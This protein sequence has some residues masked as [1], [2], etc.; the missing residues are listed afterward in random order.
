MDR[1][2]YH[3]RSMMCVP[4]PKIPTG[5]PSSSLVLTS[6]VQISSTTTSFNPE[7]SS[8]RHPSTC[9]AKSHPSTE[10]LSNLIPKSLTSKG[11]VRPWIDSSSRNRNRDTALRRCE[12][13]RR[14][15]EVCSQD[16]SDLLSR[17]L[18]P[19]PERGQT[20]AN[21]YE[22][23]RLQSRSNKKVIIKK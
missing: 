22:I 13:I 1:K 20:Q 14:V 7:F 18:E 8:P 17:V 21:A 16:K 23:F 2:S 6:V 5:S 19:A 12:E 15:R 3:S 9:W 10:S 11:H 4:F